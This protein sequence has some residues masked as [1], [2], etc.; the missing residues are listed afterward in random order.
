MEG[1]VLLTSYA[2]SPVISGARRG[3]LPARG[4]QAPRRRPPAPPRCFTDPVLCVGT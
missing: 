1:V 2:L 4:R 3:H